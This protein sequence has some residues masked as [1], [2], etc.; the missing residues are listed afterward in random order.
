VEHAGWLLVRTLQFTSGEPSFGHPQILQLD[1]KHR[2]HTAI[3]DV[4]ALRASLASV[5][6]VTTRRPATTPAR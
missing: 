4:E 3:R 5:P 1:P 6:G 2:L